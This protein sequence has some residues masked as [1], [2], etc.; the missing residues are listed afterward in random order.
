[1]ILVRNFAAFAILIVLFAVLMHQG[2]FTWLGEQAVGCRHIY[3]CVSGDQSRLLAGGAYGIIAAPILFFAARL[4]IHSGSIAR[5][6]TFVIL[7]AITLAAFIAVAVGVIIF[8]PMAGIYIF[9]A[10]MMLG[11]DGTWIGLPDMT[12][13]VVNIVSTAAILSPA[14]GWMG[15]SH[16]DR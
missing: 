8:V 13:A 2:I 9:S 4:S 7:G 6:V 10:V 1:M 5:F 15:L 12:F 3:I 11:M 16:P 14:V